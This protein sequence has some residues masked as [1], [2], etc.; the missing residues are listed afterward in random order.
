V[1]Q[2]VEQ[3]DDA[4]RYVEDEYEEEPARRERVMDGPPAPVMHHGSAVLVD[5]DDEDP[6]FDELDEPGNLPYRRAV[7]E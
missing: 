7:G 5:I 6:A 4:P 1:E 3:Y 2:P